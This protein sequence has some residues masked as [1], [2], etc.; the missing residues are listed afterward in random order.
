MT[1]FLGPK[2]KKEQPGF[3]L[4]YRTT[5]VVRWTLYFPTWIWALQKDHSCRSC[6]D[7]EPEGKVYPWNL[8]VI[9]SRSKEVH[10]S[11][12][13]GHLGSSVWW[14]EWCSGE[15]GGMSR[16]MW[17]FLPR[18][19]LPASRA[20]YP[21]GLLS[22][23]HGTLSVRTLSWGLCLPNPP[24]LFRKSNCSLVWPL[25]R[26]KIWDYPAGQLRAFEFLGLQRK[27]PMAEG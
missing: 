23:T 20:G 18:A 27:P 4:P 7:D 17:R 3:T 25:S 9:F 8:G 15:E 13:W 5:A 19:P 22:V 1:L 26:R 16:D 24:P 10:G 2:K 6:G 11:V 14:A 12:L 21:T